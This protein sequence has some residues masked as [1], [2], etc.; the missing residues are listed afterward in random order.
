MKR[1]L[2]IS[3]AILLALGVSIVPLPAQPA[4]AGT[5]IH[6]PT[7]DYPTIQS[8]I[9]AASAGDTVQ[10][11]AGTYYERISLKSRVVVQ[12]AGADVTIINGG[13]SGWI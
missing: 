13:G 10:V 9:N 7:V 12:G 6:V 4:M 11:A 3:L 1:L 5:T 8:G 2:I